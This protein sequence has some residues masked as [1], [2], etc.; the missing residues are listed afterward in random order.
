MNDDK[1]SDGQSIDTSDKNSLIN[2]LEKH[3]EYLLNI[4]K[5]LNIVVLYRNE[6]RFTFISDNYSDFFPIERGDVFKDM[7]NHYSMIK[8]GKEINFSK[9]E[10]SDVVVSEECTIEKKDSMRKKFKYKSYPVFDSDMNVSERI[11]TYEF[12]KE[13]S[14]SP[15]LAMCSCCKKIRIDNN[16]W[17]G[18]E[19]FIKQKIDAD[20]THSLCP[21]CLEEQYGDIL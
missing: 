6:C 2:N 19:E 1:Q 5:S 21:D 14:T 16:I 18:I 10:Q 9:W 20:I 4:M 13:S 3:N 17:C 15:L 7:N 8:S 12:I 11:E